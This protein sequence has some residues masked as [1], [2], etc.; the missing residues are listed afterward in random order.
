MSGSATAR[1]IQ[2][3][4]ALAILSLAP[5]LVVVMTSFTRIVI[6]FSFL[7]SALGLQQSPPNAVIISLALFLT[8]FIMAPT[9]EKSFQEG[10]QPLIEEK[11]S[12]QEAWD[13]TLAPL[14][15]FMGSQVREKDLSLFINLARLPTPPGEIEKVPFRVLIPAFIISELR[16]AFQIGFLVFMPFLI[17]D[18]VVGSIL[19]SMGMMMLPPAMIALPFKLIFFVMVDGWYLICGSLVNSFKLG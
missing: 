18:M 16:K 14:H 10:I 8:G 15:E 4:A 19:M 12:N 11:I 1:M 7:R 2:M 17:I 13:R 3:I 9:L 5:S 6:V